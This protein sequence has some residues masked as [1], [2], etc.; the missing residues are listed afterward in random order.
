[1]L[2]YFKGFVILG[3]VHYRGYRNANQNLLPS[4]GHFRLYSWQEASLL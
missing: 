1:M 2:E 3:Q 4:L